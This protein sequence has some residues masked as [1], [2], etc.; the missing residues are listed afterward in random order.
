LLRTSLLMIS[1]SS[2]LTGASLLAAA[3]LLSAAFSQA[4]VR[5]EIVPPPALAQPPWGPGGTVPANQVT[6][7]YGSMIKAVEPTIVIK[8]VRGRSRLLR[9][10]SDVRRTAVADASVADVV[11]VAPRE[12]VLLGKTVGKTDITI[13]VGDKTPQ[14]IVVLVRVAPD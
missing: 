10:R 4:L 8:L 1:R 5:A 2:I 9:A 13:W 11:Q 7:T 12:L 14:P 3:V 6:S